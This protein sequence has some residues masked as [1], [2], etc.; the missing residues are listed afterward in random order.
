MFV[1]GA[2]AA[3]ARACLPSVLIRAS[4]YRGLFQPVPN[5]GLSIL[6]GMQGVQ[7]RVC[8]RQS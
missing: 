4:L 6:P 7:W 1:S 8:R 5:A 2:A 3:G